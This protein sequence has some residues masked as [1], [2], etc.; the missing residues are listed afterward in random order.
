MNLQY[1]CNPHQR[2]PFPYN[3]FKVF[4]F[5][6][7]MT[8]CFYCVMVYVVRTQCGNKFNRNFVAYDAE[9][10]KWQRN[11]D[12]KLSKKKKKNNKIVKTI[13]WWAN[14]VQPLSFPFP[15][16]F[17]LLN[18]SNVRK[19]IYFSVLYCYST[20]SGNFMSFH[21]EQAYLFQH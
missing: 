19:K 14:K 15:I 7:S 1:C 10:S 8:F 4:F 21:F 11:F 17:L 20:L 2:S 3:L 12:I 13:L 18:L 5:L 9:N 6:T 16:F